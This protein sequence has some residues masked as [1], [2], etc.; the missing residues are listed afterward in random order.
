MKILNYIRWKNITSHAQTQAY[1]YIYIYFIIIIMIIIIMPCYEH[2]FPL[3]LYLFLSS[4]AL[5]RLSRLHPVSIHSYCIYVLAGHPSPAHRCEGVHKRM[6]LICS[7]LLLQQCSVSLVHLIRIVLE[8]EVRRPYSWCFVICCFQD[9]F[10]M[11]CSFLVQL[12]SNFF[13]PTLRVHVGHP[14]CSMD[15]TIAWIKMHFILLDRSD[16]YDW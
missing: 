9:L 15:M 11:A 4:L 5:G 8:M 10:N 16:R 3:P 14:C 1:I 7:P 12:S 13:L 6:S 2:R